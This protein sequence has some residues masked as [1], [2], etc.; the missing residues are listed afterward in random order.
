MF[1]LYSHQDPFSEHD[2]RKMP[3]LYFNGVEYLCIL[4]DACTINEASNCDRGGLLGK[5]KLLA[6]LFDTSAVISFPNPW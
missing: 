6:S 4:S 5:N 2:E 3:R 1:I